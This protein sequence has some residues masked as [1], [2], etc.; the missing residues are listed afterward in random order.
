MF[1]YLSL[2]IL[3]DKFKNSLT[4]LQYT[5]IVEWREIQ[6]SYFMGNYFNLV[7]QFLKFGF[8]HGFGASKLENAMKRIL[9][10][11]RS[12]QFKKDR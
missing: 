6:N 7:A 11:F 1:D 4:E 3:L 2:S 8:N 9:L 10:D 12:N 5:K